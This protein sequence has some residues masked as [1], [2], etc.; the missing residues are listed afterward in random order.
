MGE[1]VDDGIKFLRYRVELFVREVVLPESVSYVW[2]RKCVVI[3]LAGF[4][5]I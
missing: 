3:K 5:T 4:K 1:I 2:G